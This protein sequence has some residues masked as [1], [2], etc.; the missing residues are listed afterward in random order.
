MFL[1]PKK[2]YKSY[3]KTA[4][5]E[6]PEATPLDVIGPWPYPVVIQLPKRIYLCCF[7]AA[8]NLMAT[9]G[10]LLGPGSIQRRL[11]GRPRTLEAVQAFELAV[12]FC[13]SVFCLLQVV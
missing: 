11:V 7:V 13:P 1:L 2:A 4:A 3:K 6:E 5:L 10:P 9:A 8:R 12:F